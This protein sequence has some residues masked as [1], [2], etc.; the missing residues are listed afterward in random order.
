MKVA[1][2]DGDLITSRREMAAAI[3][4]YDPGNG[5]K[6]QWLVATGPLAGEVPRLAAL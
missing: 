6:A 3:P 4:G 2:P 1:A 5:V